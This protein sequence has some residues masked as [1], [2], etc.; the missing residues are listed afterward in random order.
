MYNAIL[1]FFA[2]HHHLNLPGVGSFSVVR[3]PAQVDFINRSLT[4]PKNKP[5]FSNDKL[6]AEKK[7]YKFLCEELNIDEMQAIRY[8]TNFVSSLQQELNENNTIQ[9]K[10]IGTISK[11]TANVFTFQPEELPEY[12]PP[13]TAERIIR[14]NA[15]HTVRVGEAEKTSEEMHT[16]LQ[17]LPV[18][19]KKQNWWIAAVVLGAIGI[20]SII[21]YYTVLK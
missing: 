13:V 18:Q 14:K 20:A 4:S 17:D 12:F 2:L 19:I 3:E 16:A 8:F 10:G 15:S 5:V 11:Q 7:F 21:L 6:P 1:K 9:L